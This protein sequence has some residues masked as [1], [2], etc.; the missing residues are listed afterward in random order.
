MQTFTF[1]ASEDKLENRG[2]T[3]A[4]IGVILHENTTDFCA[5]QTVA[6]LLM[7]ELRPLPMRADINFLRQ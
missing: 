3:A 7:L 6:V 5:S 1:Y 4:K 2:H